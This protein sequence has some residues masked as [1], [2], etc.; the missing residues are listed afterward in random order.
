MA[1]GK[2]YSDSKKSPADYRKD[3]IATQ[4]QLTMRRKENH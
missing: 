3:K 4:N 2:H 1:K